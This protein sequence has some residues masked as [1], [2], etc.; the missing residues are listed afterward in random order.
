MKFK[1]FDLSF[2]IRHSLL[3]LPALPVN[4]FEMNLLSL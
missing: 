4:G 3:D 1:V 2:D